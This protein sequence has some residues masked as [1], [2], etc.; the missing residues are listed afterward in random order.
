MRLN[1]G[2][3]SSSELAERMQRFYHPC[4]LRPSTPRS[5]CERYNRHL[6]LRKRLFSRA[7]IT[8]E[9][10]I[11]LSRV[12][13]IDCAHILNNRAGWQ[14][15]LCEANPAFL[16]VRPDLLVLHAIEPVLL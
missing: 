2:A 1:E 10:S 5:G 9:A 15:I 12:K 13:D 8:L 7:D 14:S 3:V 4:P 6:P 11:P 16:Q